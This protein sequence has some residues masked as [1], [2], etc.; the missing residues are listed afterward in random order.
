MQRS[1]PIKKLKR[2]TH[3]PA[4]LHLLQTRTLTALNP[5]TWPDQNDTTYLRRYKAARPHVKGL[6]VLC[7][8]EAADRSTTGTSMRVVPPE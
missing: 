4:L 5:A 3:L 7:M 6:F 1:G 8:T 2:Y